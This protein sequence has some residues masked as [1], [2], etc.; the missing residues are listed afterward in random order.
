MKIGLSQKSVQ[1][2]IHEIVKRIIARFDPEQIILFGSYA[3]G[4]AGSDS[5]MD[6]LVVMPVKGSKRRLQLQIR[7]A[8]HDIY[9]PMDII[10][11]DTEEFNWRKDIVGTIEW[12]AVHEG[13]VLYAKT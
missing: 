10:V 9:L 5:D 13:K 1:D 2:S 4:D 3:R 11:S 12:P 7:S 6:I 8:L